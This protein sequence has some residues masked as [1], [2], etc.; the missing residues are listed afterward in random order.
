MFKTIDNG[1]VLMKTRIIVK[2]VSFDMPNCRCH[3]LSPSNMLIY[4]RINYPN[5]FR[6]RKC[7][8]I[9][10]SGKNL[11]AV[12]VSRVLLLNTFRRYIAMIIVYLFIF[13]VL[14]RFNPENGFVPGGYN[15]GFRPKYCESVFVLFF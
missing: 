8:V 3:A 9:I 10:A 11:F 2:R 4:L 12:S 13:P 14:Y 15:N 5:I 7:Y 6:R 1:S